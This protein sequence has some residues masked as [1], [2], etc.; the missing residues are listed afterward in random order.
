[1]QGFGAGAVEFFDY[2]LGRALGGK[3]LNAFVDSEYL[4]NKKFVAN[5]GLT[6]SVK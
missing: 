4:K 5:A 2:L 3:E 1:M 6:G